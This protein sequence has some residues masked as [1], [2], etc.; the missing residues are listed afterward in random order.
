[1]SSKRT[2][3]QQ[4]LSY[5]K[6]ENL[7]HKKHRLILAFSA[8]VD[9][10]VLFHLLSQNGFD[11]DV[12]HCNFQ[13]RGEDSDAD[14]KFS[15][16]LSIKHGINCHSIRFDT[17]EEA[18]NSSDS[19]QMLARNLRYE[20][21]EKLRSGHAYDF[22]LTAH[23]QNDNI[24]TIL[25]NF[26]KGSS[27]P[28]LRGIQ[29]KS[30]FTLRPLL[31]FSKDEIIEYAK[32][33]ELEY[34]EDVSN[35]SIKY[36]RNLLRHK[37]LPILKEINPALEKNVF[38]HSQY[39]K[40]VEKIYKQG[41]DQILKK[42]IEHRGEEQYISITKLKKVAGYKTVLYAFLG[43]YGF[44]KE[45]V[46]QI[47]DAFSSGSGKTFYT[48]SHQL[49]KDRKFLILARIDLSSKSYHMIA[50][51]QEELKTELGHF[52]FQKII[53]KEPFSQ[54]SLASMIPKAENE[55]IL[56]YN[57]IQFP[58]VMRHWKKGDYF[59]P[60]GMKKKKKKLSDF[61]IDQKLSLLDKDKVWILADAKDRIVWIIGYRSDE[62]FRVHIKTKQILHIK[63]D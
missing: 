36:N 10:V 59:Y 5:V 31:P 43:P 17:E 50:I 21:F 33:N 29:A 27:L 20:W 8:G 19:I 51:D 52:S 49:I 46:R 44:N 9:S 40:D 45:Q 48:D 57:K 53:R 24:E 62:R 11:F 12:A 47:S 23:H 37:V 34:R 42:I 4:F 55:L 26:S 41:L 60:F 14:E 61:F 54:E 28:G 58:L 32:E 18:N 63:L 15:K 30:G 2:I 1:M 3:S 6:A 7:F 38:E 56:Q 25:Y 16:T 13:L 22:I 35:A 39:L